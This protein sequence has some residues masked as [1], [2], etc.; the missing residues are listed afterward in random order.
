MSLFKRS[1]RKGSN[2]I[3]L[4]LKCHITGQTFAHYDLNLDDGAVLTV[5][6]CKGTDIPIFDPVTGERRFV[7][8]A[9]HETQDG[10]KT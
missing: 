6:T 8:H 9:G 10:A 2:L 5:V 7:G 3:H 1:R 4:H